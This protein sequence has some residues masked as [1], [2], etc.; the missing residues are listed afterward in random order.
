MQLVESQPSPHFV[1]KMNFGGRHHLFL[2]T[3]FSD[4]PCGT[5]V[6]NIAGLPPIVNLPYHK[7]WIPVPI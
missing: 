6:L 2:G 4:I 5:I 7:H 3:E 1:S